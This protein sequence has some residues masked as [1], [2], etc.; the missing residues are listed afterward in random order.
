MHDK[1]TRWSNR[2]ETRPEGKR[3]V[4]ATYVK[5]NATYCEKCIANLDHEGKGEE[6]YQGCEEAC[7]TK[8]TY[9]GKRK[10]FKCHSINTRVGCVAAEGRPGL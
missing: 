8:G 1:S 9:K 6:A 2:T 10:Y 4:N 5:V 3:E 7:V